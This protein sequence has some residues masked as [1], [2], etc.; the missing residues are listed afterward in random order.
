[1]MTSS[2]AICGHVDHGHDELE[3]EGTRAR[4]RWMLGDARSSLVAAPPA[5]GRRSAGRSAAERRPAT[6][7]ASA[8][9]WRAGD[10][11]EGMGRTRGS[12]EACWRGQRRQGRPDGGESGRGGD[13]RTRGRRVWGRRFRASWLA[14]LGG[15]VEEKMVE[16]VGTSPE[17]GH[18]CNSGK[19]TGSRS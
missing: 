11:L 1:M 16:L 7:Y 18:A 15:E 4:M 6:S 14:V 17:L 2:M 9:L 10:E 12:P 3:R 19:L 13:G 5:N 8:E